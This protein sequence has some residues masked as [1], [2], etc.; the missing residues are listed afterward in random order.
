MFFAEEGYK[1]VS[2]NKG[3]ATGRV[4]C[5]ILDL[6]SATADVNNHTQIVSWLRGEGR[7][8]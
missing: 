1:G 8:S 7:I 2:E 4:T 3:K 5:E 6:M